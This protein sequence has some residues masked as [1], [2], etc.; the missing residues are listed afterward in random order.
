MLSGE[1]RIGIRKLYQKLAVK[2]TPMDELGSSDLFLHD[3]KELAATAGGDAPLPVAPDTS[4]IDKIMKYAGN[5]RLTAFYENRDTLESSI[6]V[7]KKTAAAI[8]QRLPQWEHLKRLLPHTKGVS[9]LQEHLKQVSAIEENRLLLSDPDPLPPLISTLE[10]ELRVRLQKAQDEYQTLYSQKLS[11]L[12]SD[13]AWEAM[14]PE[15]RSTGLDQCQLHGTACDDIGASDQLLSA[16]DRCPL[17]SW[18]DRTAALP[19]RFNKVR[20]LAVKAHMPRAQAID[21]PRRTLQTE[22]D[23]TDWLQEIEQLLKKNIG[24]GPIILR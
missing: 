17:Q 22:A 5:T 21:L 24:K 12:D 15:E 7:W 8:K 23:V 3:L 6:A 13:A 19:M 20:G 1:Q 14:S 2:A 18:D 9:S 11:E 16:L 4:L 10:K